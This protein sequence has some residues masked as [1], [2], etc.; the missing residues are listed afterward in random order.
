MSLH[1]LNPKESKDRDGR[2]PV[3]ESYI[4]GTLALLSRDVG[5]HAI[6]I[7]T[8]FGET[9]TNIARAMPNHIVITVDIPKGE[10][11]SMDWG[12]NDRQISESRIF[13]EFGEDV[14]ERIQFLQIDS[15]KLVLPK[16]IDLGFA[17]IDGAH[18][19]DYA[20]NDFNKVEPLLSKEGI[21]VF[22]DVI[23][24]VGDAVK[25]IIEKYKSWQ[26]S[27]YGGT[28]LVWGVKR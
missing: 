2:L 16:T 23:G 10:N 12:L 27:A 6:E 8:F 11:P 3:W 9:T 24:G 15:A 21:C 18:T 17:F 25:E 20:W 26:W 14:K 13:P 5:I 7:G 28:S 19:Y 22:H 4:V 1:K